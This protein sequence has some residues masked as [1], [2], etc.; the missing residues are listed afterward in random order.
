MKL[1]FD[2]DA[3]EEV[4]ALRAAGIPVDAQGNAERG[5]LFV[6]FGEGRGKQINIFRWFA[7]GVGQDHRD[8][9]AASRSR[10]HSAAL[11]GGMLNGWMPN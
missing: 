8:Y 11:S 2:L 3:S 6:R 5:F 4:T 7:G 10:E 1:P 9:G